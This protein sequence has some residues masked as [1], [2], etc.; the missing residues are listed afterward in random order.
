MTKVNPAAGFFN[1]KRRDAANTAVAKAFIDVLGDDGSA[2]MM[3]DVRISPSYLHRLYFLLVEIPEDSWGAMGCAKY[4][5][6]R[7]GT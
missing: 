4:Q 7:S 5:R 1:Q 2:T 6:S 3:E